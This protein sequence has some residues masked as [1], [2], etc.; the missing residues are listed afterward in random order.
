MIEYLVC[1]FVGSFIGMIVMALISAGKY[2]DQQRYLQRR[3][4]GKRKT[5]KKKIAN[6]E[7]QRRNGTDRISTR[8][9]R[10]N[11]TNEKFEKG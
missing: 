6:Y 3:D 8:R 7:W 4:S 2:D 5:V 10:E 9:E 11:I 1:C